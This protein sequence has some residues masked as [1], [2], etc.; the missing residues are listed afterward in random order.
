MVVI[1]LYLSSKSRICFFFLFFGK[2]EEGDRLKLFSLTLFGFAPALTVNPPA[3]EVIAGAATVFPDAVSAN[4]FAA[5]G[6]PY[7]VSEAHFAVSVFT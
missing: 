3:A 1:T 6:V 2:K 4:K 5:K 7:A